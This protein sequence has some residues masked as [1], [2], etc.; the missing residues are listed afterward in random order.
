MQVCRLSREAWI[1]LHPA[2]YHLN[3]FPSWY[4]LLTHLLSIQPRCIAWCHN[5]SHHY[6]I[7]RNDSTTLWPQSCTTSASSNISTYPRY[8]LVAASPQ[9][10]SLYIF[11][12]YMPAMPWLYPPNWSVVFQGC[13]SI[14]QASPDTIHGIPP[15]YAIHPR[16][17]QVPKAINCVQATIP[18]TDGYFDRFNYPQHLI[19][20]TLFPC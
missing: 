3:F 19:H 9:P 11:H 17:I 12:H 13:Y 7:I 10:I 4:I 20:D 8:H 1:I 16:T 6:L 18:G 5:T 15:P 2:M 14:D